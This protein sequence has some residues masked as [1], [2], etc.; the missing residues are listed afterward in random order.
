MINNP[1]NLI[2]L[3]C[4]AR[5]KEG[6][7]LIPAIERYDG[8]AYRVV[9][10]RLPLNNVRFVILSAQYGLIDAQQPI[11]DYNLKMTLSRAIE[12]GQCPRQQQALLSALNTGQV[13]VFGGK[14]YRQAIVAMAQGKNLD[15][16]TWQWSHGGLGYQLQQL[17]SFLDS[18]P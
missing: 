4:S 15:T 9:K 3:S 10:S 16:C 12:L 6:A 1:E 17:A 11:P 18:L 7:G 5:K 8:P 14:L 13:F 2:I